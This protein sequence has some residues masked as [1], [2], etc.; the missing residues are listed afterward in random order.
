MDT[1]LLLEV[2]Y[3]CDLVLAKVQMA[4]LHKLEEDGLNRCKAAIGHVDYL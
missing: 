4:Q 3:S 1:L 2:V